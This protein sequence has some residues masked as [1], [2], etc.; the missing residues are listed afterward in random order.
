MLSE[1]DFYH[2]HVYFYEW[3]YFK[4]NNKSW[5][6]WPIWSDSS[7]FSSWAVHLS[8]LFITL[9]AWSSSSPSVCAWYVG[10]CDADVVCVQPGSTPMMPLLYEYV[11]PG[12]STLL[13][14]G[15]VVVHMGNLRHDA[16]KP[17]TLY[18]LSPGGA[19]TIGYIICQSFQLVC[20]MECWKWAGCHNS[21]GVLQ[22]KNW[23][24]RDMK[25]NIWLKKKENK[26]IYLFLNL[27]K[28]VVR[29]IGLQT[30]TRVFRSM[31][32][33]S[34]SSS[35]SVNGHQCFHFHWAYHIKTNEWHLHSD[36]RLDSNGGFKWITNETH[37]LCCS[38]CTW[39]VHI[40]FRIC[41]DKGMRCKDL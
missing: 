38:V 15:Q 29:K 16:G 41:V 6:E 40:W 37:I 13:D 34:T 5:G 21:E 30:Q 4:I 14:T 39:V 19:E 18:I 25:P 33:V 22:Y 9:R 27:K 20:F 1:I 11:P 12:L 26:Q 10:V 8:A 28:Q 32:R 17:H 35:L 7:V 3:K 31:L 36:D 24:K 2:I 23:F